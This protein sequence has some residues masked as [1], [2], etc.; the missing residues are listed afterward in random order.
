MSELKKEELL[1]LVPS[2]SDEEL[3]QVAGGRPCGWICSYTLDCAW[4]P[5]GCSCLD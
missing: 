1:N 3:E 2:I 4:L 5:F